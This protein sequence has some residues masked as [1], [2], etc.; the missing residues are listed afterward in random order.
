MNPL[1]PFLASQPAL[2]ALADEQ[3]APK[4]PPTAPIL[5]IEAGGHTAAVQ[6]ISVDP[7]RRFLV[8]A[9]A[10]MSVRIWELTNGK[11][12]PTTRRPNSV[13]NFPIAIAGTRGS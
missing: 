9:S 10:D 4:G 5:R 6:K 7:D 1:H 11:P 12:T 8:T 3:V 2:L 13:P